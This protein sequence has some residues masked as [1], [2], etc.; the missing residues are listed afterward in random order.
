LYEYCV[1]VITDKYT[2]LSGSY[3]NPNLGPF[4]GPQFVLKFTLKL[5]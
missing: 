1:L 2:A 4:V 3:I 5:I